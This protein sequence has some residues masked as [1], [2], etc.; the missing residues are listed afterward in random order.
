MYRV[1]TGA[2]QKKGNA[3]NRVAYIANIT[4]WSSLE[5]YQNGKQPVRSSGYDSF[6][7]K[8]ADGMYRVF[9][10]SYTVRDNANKRCSELINAYKINSFILEV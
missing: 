10:G 2:Y 1:Q 7:E 8:G 6:V 5:A 4:R 3:D 9:T